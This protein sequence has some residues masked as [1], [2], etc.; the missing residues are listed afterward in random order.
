MDVLILEDHVEA[1]RWL[2]EAVWIAF[3]DATVITIADTVERLCAIISERSFDLFVVDLHLPDGSG[4]EALIFAKHHYPDMP[5]V[6]ATIYSDDD[7]LFPALRAGAAGYLL[8]DE[9]KADIAAMLKGILNG[10]PPLSPEI[11]RRLMTHFSEL[12][13]HKTNDHLASDEIPRLTGRELEALKYIVKGFSI[14]ESADLMGI[15]PHTVSGYIKDVYRK[16][17]VSSRAEVTSEAV[18]LGLV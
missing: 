12:P 3:G 15:S 14:R 17:H 7:H 2:S 13:E 4:N 9:K 10:V 11:A 1:Q 16:L 5:A 18:R 6:I 8:K